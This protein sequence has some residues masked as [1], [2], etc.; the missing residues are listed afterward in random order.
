MNSRHTHAPMRL[1]THCCEVQMTKTVTAVDFRVTIT[2]PV[3]SPI[4]QCALSIGI[5]YSIFFLSLSEYPEVGISDTIHFA[6]VILLS[7]K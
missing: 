4:A 7:L 1:V 3:V 5:Y 6:G 2:E